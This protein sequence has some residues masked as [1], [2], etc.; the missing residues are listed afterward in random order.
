M[1][2]ILNYPGEPNVI[3]RALKSGEGRQKRGER[4]GD[5][6]TEERSVRRC[7]RTIYWL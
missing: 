5:V 2:M 4:E 6:T 1:E 7:R 3:T